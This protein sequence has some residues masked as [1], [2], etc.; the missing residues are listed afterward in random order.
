MQAR[1]TVITGKVHA[2]DANAQQHVNAHKNV[3]SKLGSLKIVLSLS[4]DGIDTSIALHQFRGSSLVPWSILKRP[5]KCLIININRILKA[6]VHWG[7]LDI[8]IIR[9]SNRR[10]HNRILLTILCYLTSWNV[11]IRSI[12]EKCGSERH[13][14]D[15]QTYLGAYDSLCW[16]SSWG[17][18]GADQDTNPFHT[19]RMYGLCHSLLWVQIRTRQ[20]WTNLHYS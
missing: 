15:V 8:S 9:T 14:N 12:F 19:A 13:M 10:L 5:W 18:F 4:S 17:H 20:S 16:E 6:L 3:K 1:I 11:V 2:Q 7:F